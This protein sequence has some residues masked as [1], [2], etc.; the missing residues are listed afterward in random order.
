MEREYTEKSLIFEQ[1]LVDLRSDDCTCEK[2]QSL[3]KKYT[4]MEQKISDLQPSF[5]QFKQEFST[6]FE[7][8]QTKFLTYADAVRLNRPAEFLIDIS[9]KLNLVTENIKA[10]KKKN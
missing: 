4:A 6:K 10:Q 2:S 7:K 1:R 9:T 3:D 5:F 8:F